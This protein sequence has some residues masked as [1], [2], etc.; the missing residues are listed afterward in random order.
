[1]TSAKHILKS[2]LAGVVLISIIGTSC[3][4][5]LDVGAPK[6]ELVSELVFNDE[7][8]AIN[9]VT[10]IYGD[11]MGS[12]TFVSDYS[13]SY[14]GMAAD[15]LVSVSS[16]LNVY[17][18]NT[19]ASDKDDF[20]KSGYKYIY[21]ANIVREGTE[22]SSL[23][24][25]TKRQ[26]IGELL[27]VRAFCHFYMVNLFGDIPYMTSTDYRVTNVAP[28]EPVAAVYAKILKDLLDARDLVR[29]YYVEATNKPT[30]ERI[31]PNKAVVTAM[32]ARVYLYMGNWA[33]AEEE[34]TTLINNPLY[35]L[36]TLMS[37]V[38][39]RT[40]TEAIFQLQPSSLTYNNGYSGPNFIIDARPNSFRPV[41]SDQLWNAFEPGDKRQTEWLGT[42]NNFGTITHF[43]WKYKIAQVP[44]PAQSEFHMVLRLA[45]Q[46][47]IR[48]EAR[49]NL[50][51]FAG[52]AQDLNKLR[53]RAR[54]TP[55]DL[56]DYP[57]TLDKAQCLAKVELERQRELFTEMGHRWL[58]LKRTGRADAVMAPVKGTKW[59][60]TDQLFPLP[61]LQLELN[62]NMTGKQNPG[63]TL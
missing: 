7:Q 59:Q 15:E 25:S 1:M 14:L 50:N 61:K 51:N 57:E 62:P 54:A 18:T 35:N 43:A 12:S 3:K 37:S 20:W 46:Y 23:L 5:F 4:K 8:T 19:L 55:T 29:E 41:L 49:A 42:F 60:T 53:L 13:S 16:P 26:M 40:S 21:Q 22:R 63:Y 11:M 31:R 28:R 39:L 27:F 47:L 10:S 38:F 34:A 58:D 52:A 24:D 33:K 30:T 9:A 56:P 2:A 36:P 44:A 45:E 6:T 17:F 48:A 32:L